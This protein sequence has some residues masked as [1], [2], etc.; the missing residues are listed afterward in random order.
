MKC[1]LYICFLSP[2]SC[3][4]FSPSFENFIVCY[5]RS[6]R[7]IYSE[8]SASYDRRPF[9]ILPHIISHVQYHRI[10]YCN[11]AI[12]I[13]I[14]LENSETSYISL[15]RIRYCDKTEHAL[16]F[17]DTTSPTEYLSLLLSVLSC[18]H[19]LEHSIFI[20]TSRHPGS[21]EEGR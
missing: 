4:F 8:W 12:R 1:L 15:C 16:L 13:V 6:D 2:V 21:G 11:T 9:Q 20:A 7:K 10:G 17:L 19:F 14:V 18:R 3:N 5:V